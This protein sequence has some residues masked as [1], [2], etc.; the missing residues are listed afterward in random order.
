M[1]ER[2]ENKILPPFARYEKQTAGY[3]AEDGAMSHGI[4]AVTPSGLQQ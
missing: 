3:M 4:T 1:Y 2:C